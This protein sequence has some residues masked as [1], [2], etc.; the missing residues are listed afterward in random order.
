LNNG[1]EQFGA[2]IYVAN[3]IGLVRVR[4]LGPLL[5]AIIERVSLRFY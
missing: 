2:Q 5:A 4:E 1:L 3:M